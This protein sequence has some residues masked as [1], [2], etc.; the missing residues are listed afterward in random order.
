MTMR[1]RASLAW[2]L[3]PRLSCFLTTV[4]NDA[5]I[6]D[7][8]Q[9]WAKS[10]SSRSRSGLSPAA[11]R[12]V[13]A[14]TVPTP[15][16]ATSSGAVTATSGLKMALSSAKST[17][18]S[19]THLARMRSAYFVPLTAVVGSPGRSFVAPRTR[20]TQWSPELL[21]QLLGAREQQ[22]PH[23]V[24]GLDAGVASGVIG[25]AKGPD[26]FVAAAMASTGSDLPWLRRRWRFG[27]LTSTTCTPLAAK[28]RV[29]PAP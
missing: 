13:P 27:Q 8:P 22:G 12:R 10:H 23:L 16:R 19:K 15:R 7:T 2:R 26:C 11:T 18:S 6:G 21:A 4:P 20:R 17:S 5:S 14:V 1:H 9:K 24:E 29:S 25:G 28:N 3:P